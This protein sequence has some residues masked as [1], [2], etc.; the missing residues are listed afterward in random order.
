[1]RMR[2]PGGLQRNPG[3]AHLSAATLKS[4]HPAS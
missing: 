4:P 3:G 1:V 2:K